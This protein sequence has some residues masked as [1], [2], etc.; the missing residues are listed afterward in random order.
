MQLCHEHV[1]A[2]NDMVSLLP[3]ATVRRMKEAAP[4]NLSQLCCKVGMVRV[5][6]EMCHLSYAKFKY[7]SKDL[8]VP[9][10]NHQSPPIQPFSFCLRLN[11][12]SQIEPPNIG[13]TQLR[14][15]TKETYDNV[16][17]S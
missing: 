10:K 12:N 7:L 14:Q 17:T 6:I 13:L 11:F 15:N 5:Q 2:A 9:H 3:P 1:A 8:N 4:Q 16:H